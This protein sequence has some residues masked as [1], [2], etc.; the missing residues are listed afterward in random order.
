MDGGRPLRRHDRGR[1]GAQ[2]CARA[3]PYALRARAPLHAARH[4]G[5]S[6]VA[7]YFVMIM[8]TT[9]W[10]GSFP[11]LELPRII[12]DNLTMDNPSYEGFNKDGGKY[13]VRAKTAIQ[14]LVN[15]GSCASTTSPATDRRKKSK[16]NL[17]AAKGEFNTKTNQAR[18]DRRHRHRRRERP[19]GQAD[20]RHRSHQ[21]QHHQ[22]QGAGAGRDAVG[23]RS[24]ERDAYPQQEPRN[25]FRP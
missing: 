10:T 5:R 4:R 6:V 19:Q 22:L 25:R 24:L 23:H 13:V 17:T 14:D 8:D 1:S 11:K 7:L 21:R 9:G 15:T 16:T 18:A 20:E 3:P 2:F 12:P